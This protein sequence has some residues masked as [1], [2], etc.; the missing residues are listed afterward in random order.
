MAADKEQ[1]GFAIGR[2]ELEARQHALGDI[3]AGPHVVVGFRAFSDIVE[4]QRK[5]E[6]VGLFEFLQKFGVALIPFGLRLAQ[7]MEIV[8]RYKR[9]F[10]D[11]EAM[12]IIANYQRIDFPKFRKQERQQAQRMH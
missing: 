12:R 3:N 2:I 8:D 1:N 10:I 9:V 11:R 7:C 5:V 4:K 6:Q